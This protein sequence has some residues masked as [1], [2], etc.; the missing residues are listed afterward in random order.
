M[1]F[2]LACCQSSGR[3]DDQTTID[4]LGKL[5][6]EVACTVKATGL[7]ALESS[8]PRMGPI[9]DLN[10]REDASVIHEH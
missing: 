6:D 5:V 10:A 7:K 3:A 2:R 4:V 1:P 9:D 8:S